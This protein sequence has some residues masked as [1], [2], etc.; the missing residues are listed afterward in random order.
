ML[1]SPTHDGRAE[2]IGGQEKDRRAVIYRRLALI[3]GT[4]PR[5]H[6][7]LTGEGALF[8]SEAR[9]GRV[10]RNE[11]ARDETRLSLDCTLARLLYWKRGRRAK[12]TE[13]HLH[14]L[15]LRESFS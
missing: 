11:K 9:Q 13:P 8:N 7:I 2:N 1:A 10:N 3:D 15:F 4:G 12:F 14:P 6:R 5:K